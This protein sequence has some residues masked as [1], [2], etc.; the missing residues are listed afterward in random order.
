MALL[1]FTLGSMV[2]IVI[3]SLWSVA[4][5][6]PGAGTPAP[7]AVAS[8]AA[9]SAD[10]GR[11]GV[12]D[13]DVAAGLARASMPSPA[14]GHLTYTSASAGAVQPREAALRSTAS[15]TAWQRNPSAKV[16][17]GETPSR[18]PSR[19]SLTACTKVCS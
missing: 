13:T 7:T 19:R 18:M 6:A 8:P 12:V 4:N 11:F 10:D 16:G 17:A 15:S 9:E 5:R 14:G 2:T 1:L 3:G